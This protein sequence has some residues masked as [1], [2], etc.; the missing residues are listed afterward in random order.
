MSKKHNGFK[1]QKQND[2][3]DKSK[4]TTNNKLISKTKNR[5]LSKTAHLGKVEKG[6]GILA[7]PASS[8]HRAHT[9]PLNHCFLFINLEPGVEGC[10]SLW[11]VNTSPLQNRFTFLRSSCSSIETLGR[12]GGVSRLRWNV[13]FIS[14]QIIIWCVSQGFQR[15]I[16][17]WIFYSKQMTKAWNTM[18]PDIS[19]PNPSL[20]W[21]GDACCVQDSAGWNFNYRWK[22][23]RSNTSKTECSPL[24]SASSGNL[25]KRIELLRWALWCPHKMKLWVP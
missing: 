18:N 25:Q 9:I 10:K 7:V 12:S 24:Y 20:K 8:A 15:F 14:E 23:P 17:A 13:N 19:C 4:L 6:L 16:W 11:T 5:M 1:D 2:F 3:E 21:G 22:V